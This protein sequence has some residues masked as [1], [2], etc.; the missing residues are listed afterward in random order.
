MEI[1]K[2]VTHAGV[3]HADDVFS[4]SFLKMIWPNA[5]VIRTFK[6]E[7]YEGQD[8]VIIYDIG[9]G[10]FDHHQTDKEMRD[11]NVPYASFGLLWRE[12]STNENFALGLVEGG[13]S[14]AKNIDEEFIYAIDAADNGV[15]LFDNKQ[16]T[17]VSGIIRA[18]NPTWDS[19]T[20]SDEAF[21]A[22]VTIATIILGNEINRCCSNYRAI[23]IVREAAENAK[24]EGLN[25]VALDK[26]VPWQGV[27]CN[28]FPEMDYIIY[29]GQRGG[30]NI[31]TIPVEMGSTT[32]KKPF[33]EEWRGKS[34]D[35]LKNIHPELA[36]CHN[37]GFLCVVNTIDGCIEIIN[38]LL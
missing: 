26:F 22:A 19:D 32:S 17:T 24:A 3:F 15:M 37:T 27:I 29:P 23:T 34:P 9:R 5:E 12:F 11:E 20:T 10:K 8:D 14:V 21:N 35:E 7:Q 16:I 36:F 30:F 1:T 25:Y 31:Q 2:L 33:P 6:P 18:F 4:T 38:N 13:E 28:D